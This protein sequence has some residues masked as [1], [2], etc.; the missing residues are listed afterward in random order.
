MLI[1]A[2]SIVMYNSRMRFGDIIVRM[3]RGMAM[4]MAPSPPIANL[5]MAIPESADI[6]P[7]FKQHLPLY[8]RFIDDGLAAWR[9]NPDLATDASIQGRP[10]FFGT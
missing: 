3:I 6:I 7:T 2:I 10:Q 5:F 1:E 8:V 4:G 9:C